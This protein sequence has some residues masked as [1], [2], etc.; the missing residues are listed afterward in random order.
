MTIHVETVV[1]CL[2]FLTI[3]QCFFLCPVGSVHNLSKMRMIL[4]QTSVKNGNFNSVPCN[5]KAIISHYLWRVKHHELSLTEVISGQVNM[6]T[7]IITYI[8]Y[9]VTFFWKVI[10]LC[11][12]Y[13]PLQVTIQTGRHHNYIQWNI[14]IL[15]IR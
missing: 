12:V 8:K 15:L 3:I 4:W 10:Q 13:P 9:S 14:I 7:Y 11:A 5:K 6:Y 2:W 1:K